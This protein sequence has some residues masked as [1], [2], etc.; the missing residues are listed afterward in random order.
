LAWWIGS[1]PFGLA[2]IRLVRGGRW[3][4]AERDLEILDLVIPLQPLAVDEEGRR[5]IDL[6]LVIGDLAGFQ[7]L[8]EQ[9]LVS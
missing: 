5:R 8:A 1:R 9:L 6:K 2:L 3:G 7:D 4:V